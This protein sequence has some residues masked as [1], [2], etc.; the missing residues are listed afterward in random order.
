MGTYGPLPGGTFATDSLVGTIAWT[1]ASNAQTS[2][3]SYATSVLLLGQVTNYL[4]VT[5]LGF[6]IPTD[7]SIAGI[8]VNVERST[9]VLN[10]TQ[11]NS[12]KLAVSSSPVGDDKASANLWPTADATA[13]YGSA[14][15]LWGTTWT[16]SQI[17][18]STFGVEI[19]AIADLGG[20]AQIDYV[21][22]TVDYTGS[23]KP[24]NKLRQV[25][26]GNGLSV[27]EVN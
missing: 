18:D 21:T 22:I 13:T 20:T 12:I 16:P 19:S 9:T 24:G 14:T 25:K 1:S 26:A 17:N 6:G 23:N 4:K 2:D 15:D 5:N 3:N 8:T 11:D 7:A 27:S 10:A